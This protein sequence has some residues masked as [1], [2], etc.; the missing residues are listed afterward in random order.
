[1]QLAQCRVPIDAG[2]P[3]VLVDHFACYHD[4]VHGVG[5]PS[6]QHSVENWSL[7][8]EIGISEFVPIDQHEI[9]GLADREGAELP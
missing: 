1:M 9:G 2:E 6:L 3:S 4:K 7:R 5:A 8:V